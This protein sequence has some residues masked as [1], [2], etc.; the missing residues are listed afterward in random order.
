MHGTD[1]IPAIDRLKGRARR[2]PLVRHWLQR[3]EDRA[4]VAWARSADECPPPSLF[5]Q[6]IVRGYGLRLGATTFVE[7]GT[8]LG[9]MVEAVARHFQ[10]VFSIEL[11]ERLFRRARFRLGSLANVVL[12]QGDSSDLLAGVIPRIEGRCVFWLDGHYSGGQTGRGSDNTPIRRELEQIAGASRAGDVI[13]I[14]DARH[15]DGRNGYPTL[16]ETALFLEQRLHLVVA[17]AE[18]VIR[19]T[20]WRG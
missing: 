12:L 4:L 2:H 5:K 6:H 9:E 3:R 7:T 17:V 1:R 20:P 15:F 14:D 13:L 18:D 8:Y 11:D 10:F 19:A 16:D